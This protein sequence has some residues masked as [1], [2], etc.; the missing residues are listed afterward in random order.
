M[1]HFPNFV[2]IIAQKYLSEK[3]SIVILFLLWISLQIISYFHFGVMI[4]VDSEYYI[5][6]ASSIIQGELPQNREVLYLT[7]SSLIALLS[8]IGLEATWIVVLQ[9][10]ISGMALYS[11][12]RITQILSKNNLTPFVA[13]LLYILWFKFQQWNLIVYT[14]ALFTNSVVISVYLLM[15]AK[16]KRSYLATVVIIIFTA[17]IRPTGIGFLIAILTYVIF[18]KFTFDKKKPI[19]KISVSVLFLGFFLV[20]L[21]EVLKDYVASFLQSYANAEIIYPK[22]SFGIDKSENLNMPNNQHQPLIQLVLFMVKNPYYMIKISLLKVI[23]FLGHIKPY[24]SLFHNLMIGCFLY[25]V[26]FF[27]V[28]GAKLMSK[29]RLYV[30]IVV[31]LGFQILIVSLTS[32]NWDGRFLLPLLPWIFILSSFG[33]SNSVQKIPNLKQ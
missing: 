25:P 33:I 11:I 30:F 16:N 17:F 26:Y 24:Y 27:A 21:N 4:S 32:E 10:I 28:K 31:F 2:K 20:L 13:S 23:L 14:D 8:L 22:I 6:T 1:L 15:V 12:Y 19:L 5:N 7:Y 9:I 18:D 3:T 29:N